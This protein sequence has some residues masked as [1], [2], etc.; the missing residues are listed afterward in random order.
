MLIRQVLVLVRL[1]KFKDEDAEFKGFKELSNAG[2]TIKC[3]NDL[4]YVITLKQCE[5]LSARNIEYDVIK[6]E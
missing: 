3:V 6:N 4:K 5:L 2:Q 1:V